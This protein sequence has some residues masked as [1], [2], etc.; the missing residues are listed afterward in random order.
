MTD[1]TRA[2]QA[3]PLTGGKVL[4]IFLG[5]F[6]VVFGVNFLMAFDAVS[7]F[8][9]ESANHPYEV[10]LKFNSELAAA[11]AQSERHWKVDVAMMDGL[12]ATFRDADGRAIEGLAVSGVFAAPADTMRDRAFALV[13]T[14]PGVYAGAAAPAGVW[15]L[16]ISA[17]RDSQTIFQ[18][19]SRLILDVPALAARNDE[20]WRAGLNLVGGDAHVTFRDTDGRPVAGLAVSGKFAAPK[21]DRAR[22]RAFTASE[23]RPGDYA[24]AP[25]ALAAGAWDLELDAKRGAETLFQSRNGVDVR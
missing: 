7:T 20:H 6:G 8:R 19:A 13:E 22:D 23:V 11:A 17:K 12:S 15:D 9:G 4:A 3:A 2:D 16:Q 21:G 18:S 5:F 10:G 1:S 24:I 25:A 14:S